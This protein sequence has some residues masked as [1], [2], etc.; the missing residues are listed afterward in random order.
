MDKILKFE[1]EEEGFCYVVYSVVND[2][3]QKLFYCFMQESDQ[4]VSLYRMTDGTEHCDP[5]PIHEVNVA[6]EIKI[7]YPPQEYKTSLAD[8]IR[9]YINLESNIIGVPYEQQD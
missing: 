2:D 1:H 4:S 3:G 8:A 9:S 6:G 7:Q 5:E